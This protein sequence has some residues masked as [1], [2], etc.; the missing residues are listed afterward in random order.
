MKLTPRI[1]AAISMWFCIGFTGFS[2][3]VDRIG[4]AQ[5]AAIVAALFGLVWLICAAR[6]DLAD[7]NDRCANWPNTDAAPDVPW[8]HYSDDPAPL[9]I[10]D[11]YTPSHATEIIDGGK[12]PTWDTATWGAPE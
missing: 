8:A 2:F 11:L 12:K 7:M 4:D 6:E 9:R 3:G 5:V 10:D 1:A